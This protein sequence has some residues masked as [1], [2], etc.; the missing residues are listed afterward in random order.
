[1]VDQQKIA[2]SANIQLYTYEQG[3]DKW[4]KKTINI[5]STILVRGNPYFIGRVIFSCC[6]SPSTSSISL[7]I[8]LIIV[9]KKAKIAGSIEFSIDP[10]ATPP[11]INANPVHIDTAAFP[12]SGIPLKDLE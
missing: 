6:E 8:S 1:M 9:I 3:R 11:N 2:Q 10:T 5:N 7:I 12:T 4:L